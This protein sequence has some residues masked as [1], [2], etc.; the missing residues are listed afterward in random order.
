M[1][2][3]PATRLRLTRAPAKVKASQPK[4]LEKGDGDPPSH[5]SPAQSQKLDKAGF[6]L[7]AEQGGRRDGR[8]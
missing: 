2:P 7:S 6:G 4:H 8:S 5:G 3:R 1:T